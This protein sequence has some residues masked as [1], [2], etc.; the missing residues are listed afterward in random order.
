MFGRPDCS[1]GNESAN[2]ACI[3]YV[4]LLTQHRL[5]F[6]Y[7]D[8]DC[9]PTYV[10]LY[11]IRHCLCFACRTWLSAYLHLGS[12][13]RLYCPLSGLPPSWFLIQTTVHLVAHNYMP[14]DSHEVGIVHARLTMPCIL[15]VIINLLYANRIMRVDLHHL[16]WQW[17]PH[18]AECHNS[19]CQSPHI[20]HD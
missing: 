5:F 7:V 6:A 12:R 9:L 8:R 16:L 2:D 13:P 14:T 20:L 11:Y 15:L 17:Y 19:Q 18:N 3:L 1:E 4:G 10:K